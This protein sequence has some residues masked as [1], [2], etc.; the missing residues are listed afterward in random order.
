MKP[1]QRVSVTQ[2]VVSAIKD[3]IIDGQYKV[4]EKLPP[5]MKLCEILK[6]S[7]SAIR[8]AMQALQVAGYVELISGR[9]AFVR[10]NQPHDYNTVRNWFIEEAPTLEDY[11]E[12]R[13]AIEPLA[14]KMAIQR[15]S[16]EE[17]SKLFHIHEDFIQ[18]EKDKNISLM[19]KLDEQFHSQIIVM[20]HN[21]LLQKI[22]TLLTEELKKYRVMSI[23]AKE[24]SNNTIREHELICD[25]IQ[26]RNVQLAIAAMLKHLN[27]T[28]EDMNKVLEQE[29]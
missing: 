3:S 9:G 26:N 21:N 24:Q 7:R 5:E 23:S 18:A 19:A 17:L 2:Q 12:V 10:D 6:V 25:S 29:K 4:G 1:I 16:K 22:N 13:E 15:G 8:E 20:S 28:L 11:A 27:M 14:V